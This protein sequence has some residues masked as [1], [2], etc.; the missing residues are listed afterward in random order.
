[1]QFGI[2]SCKEIS[3]IFILR[4]SGRNF[5]FAGEEQSR[6]FVTNRQKPKSGYSAKLVPFIF[7]QLPRPLFSLD[8]FIA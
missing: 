3:G 1:L 7:K 5:G 6:S 2:K 8:Y 4:V